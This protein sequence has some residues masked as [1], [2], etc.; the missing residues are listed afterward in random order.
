MIHLPRSLRRVVL[1]VGPSKTGTTSLQ[2]AL[3]EHRATLRVHGI[4]Y[5]E[6]IPA[7]RE[8]QHSLAWDILRATGHAVRGPGRASLSWP[9]ALAAARA[10]R[11]H[12]LLISSEEF[13]D[14]D[15]PAMI[16]LR[17]NLGAIPVEIIFALR[18][19][20]AVIASAWRQGVKWGFGMGEECLDLDDA[21]RL[22]ATADRIAVVPYLERARALLRPTRIGLFT[23]PARPDPALLIRRFA[24]AAALPRALGDLTWSA[25]G[26]ENRSYSLHRT[27]LLLAINRAMEAGAEPGTRDLT[28]GLELRP[29]ILDA[30]ERL[31]DPD[32][33]AQPAVPPAIA[34]ALR[35][36]LLR[37]L[38]GQ[39]VHGTLAD[40]AASPAVAADAKVGPP[41]ASVDRAA[42]IALCGALTGAQARIAALEAGRRR[43]KQVYRGLRDAMPRG[44]AGQI[45]RRLRAFATGAEPARGMRTR[46]LAAFASW[47]RRPAAAR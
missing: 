13:S 4:C 17:E 29:A 1:H 8:G 46:I 6:T 19:P 28:R 41:A 36:R 22:L 2:R 40:L 37:W 26:V 10:D 44:L 5:P 45:D 3:A 47:R 32:P 18:D 31:A 9:R 43:W 33:S 7:S 34:G 23:V 30:I 38:G 20:A 14:F 25:S 35:E 15:A 27:R 21:A 12:T 39:E 16:R 24:A 42:L 11:A